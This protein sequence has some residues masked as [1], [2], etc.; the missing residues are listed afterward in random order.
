MRCKTLA[1][2][3]LCAAV[4]GARWCV[5]APPDGPL[6]EWP[7][8]GGDAGGSR[9]SPLTQITKANV[10]ALRVAWEY[11]TGEVSDGSGGRRPS[12]FE[13]TPIVAN[14]TLYVATFN[15]LF[16]IAEGASSKPAGKTAGAGG[17]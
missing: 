17:Q 11:H 3:V 8:Y 15:T 14:G 5:A 6:A 16:A 1:A 12:A 7:S 10:A 2:L 9:Y 4:T 13:A